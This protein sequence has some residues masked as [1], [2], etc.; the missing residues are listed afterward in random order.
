MDVSAVKLF[1]TNRNGV[2][3]VNV[4]IRVLTIR[5]DRINGLGTIVRT[6][7]DQSVYADPTAIEKDIL[8]VGGTPKTPP[9]AK[10]N[11]AKPAPAP[12]AT[13]A[14]APV[15]TGAVAAPA[16]AGAVVVMVAP[17]AAAPAQLAPRRRPRPPSPRLP[18]RRR[19][20]RLPNRRPIRR[21]S[22]STRWTASS[23]NA[24]PA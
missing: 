9:G 10:P 21:R 5:A 7:F 19:L 4:V 20:M 2:E 3:P 16:P 18:R 15:P 14:P 8:V 23:S 17:A 1:A 24:P 6:V 22:R 13:P 11:A 12:A